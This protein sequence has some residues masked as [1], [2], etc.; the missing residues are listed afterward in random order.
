MPGVCP[1]QRN[2]SG[3]LSFTVHVQRPGGLLFLTIVTPLPVEHIIG[4]V[5]HHQGSQLRRLLSQYSHPLVVQQVGQL[6]LAFSLIHRRVSGGVNDNI[7]FYL[8]NG[9][10]NPGEIRQIAAQFLIKI[11]NGDHFTQGGKRT[12]QLPADL[13]IFPNK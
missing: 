11:V 1:L 7:R 5:M 4:G 8:A 10:R 12:L 3:T 2:F 6:T 9:L 13:T